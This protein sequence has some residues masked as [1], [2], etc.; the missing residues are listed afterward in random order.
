MTFYCCK[1]HGLGAGL[2]YTA[3]GGDW[4][5]PG[6]GLPY[7]TSGGDWAGPGGGATPIP[8]VAETGWGLG[9]GLG[10]TLV[11]TAHLE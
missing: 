11:T 1:I 10:V 9:V 6:V 7:T 3:S 4:A 5:G 8:Q 2:P